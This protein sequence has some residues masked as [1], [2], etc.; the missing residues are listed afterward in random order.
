[1]KILIRIIT[2]FVFTQAMIGC[3]GDAAFNM[4]SIPAKITWDDG[5]SPVDAQGGQCRF[6]K[7][8]SARVLP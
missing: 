1:M 6:H 5:W 2:L 7:D 8:I 3:K 4:Q